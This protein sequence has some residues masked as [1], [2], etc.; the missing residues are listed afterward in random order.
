A[1]VETMRREFEA[2]G[3]AMHERLSRLPGVKCIEPTAAYYC[4]ADVRGAYQRLGVDGSVAFAQAVLDRVHVA[5]VPGVAFG[6]DDHVR[7]SFACSME[8]ITE[9]MSRLEKLFQ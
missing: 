7:L 6:S 9:G 3:R 8:Q 5:L 4:F 2:R 1:G